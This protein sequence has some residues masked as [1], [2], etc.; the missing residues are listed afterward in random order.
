MFYVPC[1]ETHLFCNV[2]HCN[3]ISL[4]SDNGKE[5]LSMNEVMYYLIAN[6]KSLIEESKLEELLTMSQS[7]WQN[8]ADEVK[9]LQLFMSSNV[10]LLYVLRSQEK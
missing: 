10:M 6:S 1:P 3:K 9:G 2:I 8:F 5:I 4:L 7:K